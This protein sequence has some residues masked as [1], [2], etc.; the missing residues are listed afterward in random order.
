MKHQTLDDFLQTNGWSANLKDKLQAISKNPETKYLV[1]WDNAGQMSASAYTAKPD[2]WPETAVAIWSK[3]KD[4]DPATKSRTMLAVD[5]V[6]ND[7][8]TVYA[9]AKALGIN[10]SA[11]HRA[12]KRREDKDVC[13]QCNQVIRNQS[14]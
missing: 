2:E 5:R 8:M 7:G 10:Q 6:E 13:P 9:A 1:A 3:D 12:I 4:L 11:V 14:A